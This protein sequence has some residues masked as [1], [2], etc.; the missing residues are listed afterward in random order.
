MWLIS[1]ITCEDNQYEQQIKMIQM[2]LLTVLCADHK[3][4]LLCF[5]LVVM[6]G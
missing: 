6:I 1:K 2:K 5:I 4:H 3:I